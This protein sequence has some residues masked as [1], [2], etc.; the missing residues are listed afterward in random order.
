MNKQA[1]V[2]T[3]YGEI[4]QKKNEQGVISTPLFLKQIM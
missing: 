3:I 2:S 1:Y 4:Y